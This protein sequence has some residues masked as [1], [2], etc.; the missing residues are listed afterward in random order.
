MSIAGGHVHGRDEDA[1]PSTLTW[2]HHD[3]AIG[4]AAPTTPKHPDRGGI[5]M[6]QMDAKD[7]K[8]A[9]TRPR[10]PGG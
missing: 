9:L 5:P 8:S 7:L 2:S 3:V 4:D 6:A 1:A 10:R